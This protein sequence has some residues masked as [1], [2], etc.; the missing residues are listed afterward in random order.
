MKKFFLSGI[1]VCLVVVLFA[2]SDKKVYI[3]VKFPKIVNYAYGLNLV[4]NNER[5]GSF[6]IRELAELHLKGNKN[7]QIELIDNG[8]VIGSTQINHFEDSIMYY[9]L[10]VSMKTSFDEMDKV[11]GG[12]YVMQSRNY[13]R[14][15]TFYENGLS[16]ASSKEGFGTGFQITSDGYIITNN[17]VTDGAKKIKVKGI[18]GDYTTQYEA[19]VVA[20]DVNNDLVILQLKNKNIKF[21]ETAFTIRNSGANTGEDIFVLGYPM[22][23]AMGEE[24]KLTTGVISS[25]SGYEGNISSY[26]VSAPVQPGN[27]GGP[28]FDKDGNLIG[29]I[30]SK[31]M[32]AEN[33]GYAIKSVYLQAILGMLPSEAKLT[34]TSTLKEKTLAEKVA[35]LSKSVY[36]IEVE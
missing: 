13:E 21:S 6:K 35:L 18:E 36:I 34:T 28:L 33:V 29:V 5:L 15:L 23:T 26:Q 8:R 17:H 19:D 16:E 9:Q 3:W 32:N 27:S 14:K 20:K 30:N 10:T 2:G 24:V 25:K 12:L 22:K 31:I 11:K 7:Y 1:M 4:V